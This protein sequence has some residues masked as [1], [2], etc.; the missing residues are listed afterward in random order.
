M[1][2][3]PER[4]M[5]AQLSGTRGSR[6]VP[7]QFAGLPDTSKRLKHFGREQDDVS[8]VPRDDGTGV[9]R[10]QLPYKRQY[11]H[12]RLR[13]TDRIGAQSMTSSSCGVVNANLRREGGW[14]C[15][16]YKTL[17]D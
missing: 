17:H 12:C 4:A 10:R 2:P 1:S 8:R 11:H 3:V 16:A 5:Y 14:Q 6:T 7:V 15:L 9:V 13:M